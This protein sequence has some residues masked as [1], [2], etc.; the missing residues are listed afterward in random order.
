VSTTRTLVFIFEGPAELVRPDRCDARPLLETLL[1]FVDLIE[2]IGAHEAVDTEEAPFAVV[3]KEVRGGSIE[4]VLDFVPRYPVTSGAAAAQRAGLDAVRIAAN[5]LE[6]RDVGPAGIRASARKLAASLAQLPSHTAAHL[7]G[8]VEVP[9]SALAAAEPSPTVV[10][11][12]S[13]RARILRAGGMSPRVQL[14]VSGSDR[15]I[16]LDAPEPLAKLA[17]QTLYAEAD[18]T[19]K[20]ERGSDD[21]LLHG[22]LSELRI[23]EEG[24]PVEAFDRWYERAGR[25]WAKVK[26]IEKGLGRGDGA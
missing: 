13:F 19:A 24:D 26:D 14:K 8:S 15:P 2:R 5:F 18:V 20:V 9:L 23:I 1:R 16:T 10:S 21:R 12:E 3:L 7:R 6:R 4:Y 11:V 17:G 25:P 22:V